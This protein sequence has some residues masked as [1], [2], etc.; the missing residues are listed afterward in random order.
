M[1]RN[2]KLKKKTKIH[3]W[4]E[5]RNNKYPQRLTSYSHYT[6]LLNIVTRATITIVISN[7]ILFLILHI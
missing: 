2:Q 7:E 6:L 1:P 4:N 5:E 3:T